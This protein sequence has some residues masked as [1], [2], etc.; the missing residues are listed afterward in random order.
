MSPSDPVTVQVDKNPEDK[1]GDCAEAYRKFGPIVFGEETDLQIPQRGQS[2]EHE[3]IDGHDPAAD[4]VACQALYRGVH[5]R[6]L[7]E[8]PQA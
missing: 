8:K 6:K 2:R 3:H 1:Y 7:G 5:H 4:P